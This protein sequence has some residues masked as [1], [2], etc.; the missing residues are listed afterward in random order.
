MRGDGNSGD[1][2]SGRRQWSTAGRGGPGRARGSG[3]VAAQRRGGG[4]G[5]DRSGGG[6]AAARRRVG[7]GGC[8]LRRRRQGGSGRAAAA[9]QRGSV[10]AGRAGRWRGAAAAAGRAGAGQR[11]CWRGRGRE[12]EKDREG[13][14]KGEGEGVRGLGEGEGE[15]EGDGGR[16]SVCSRHTSSSQGGAAEGRRR[17]SSRASPGRA[18]SAGRTCLQRHA[19]R[20]APPLAPAP[21]ACRR[22][23]RALPRVAAPAGWPDP[24]RRT[25]GTRGT[26]G[27]GRERVGRGKNGW[28]RRGCCGWGGGD[29]GV[30]GDGHL[31]GA[32]RGET[33]GVAAA[34]LVGEGCVG[35]EA[36][37]GDA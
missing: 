31:V 9:R 27:E 21:V 16:E 25:V 20:A 11:R 14:G 33:E 1:S 28:G 12:G 36:L 6:G 7:Q 37:H 13:K 19:G 30:V 32:R 22:L 8:C 3:C 2:G 35:P 29:G 10:A 15:V 4:A 26:R 34:E 17:A 5:P 24:R 18:D 23:P